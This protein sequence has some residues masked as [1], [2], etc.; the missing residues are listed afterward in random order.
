[1]ERT[2]SYCKEREA[3]EQKISDFEITKSKIADMTTEL[4]ASRLLTYL[5]AWKKWK[6]MEYSSE[7]AQAKLFSSESAL[8]ICNAAIQMHGGF[9]YTDE[10]DIHRHWR[11]AKLMTIGEGTSEIMKLIIAG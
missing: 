11:D 4:N 5:A 10:S 6:K 2:I 9:G 3:F 8:K 7:A 1:L